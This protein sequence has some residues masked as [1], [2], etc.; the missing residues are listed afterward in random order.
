MYS[1]R[2]GLTAGALFIALSNRTLEGDSVTWALSDSLVVLPEGSAGAPRGPGGARSAWLA[3]AALALLV[4]A[5]YYPLRA[6]GYIWDDDNYVLKNIALRSAHGL[7]AIWVH[8]LHPVTPQYYP[9]TF[10]TFWVEYHLWGL[11]PLGFHVVNVAL[12]AISTLVLWRLLRALHVPAAWLAAAIFALHPVHVESVAWISER[13][14]VLS[15]L[16]YLLSLASY[17]RW[18]GI[19]R[20]AESKDIQPATPRRHLWYAAALLLFAL[21]LFSKTVTSSLPAV[22]LLMIYWKKG[23]IRWGDA[24]SLIPFFALGLTLG[25]ITS[26]LERHHVG[27]EGPE[28]DFSLLQRVGI[29]G[30]NAWFYAAKLIWPGSLNFIYPRWDLTHAAPPLL[31]AAAALA[32]P[33]ALWLAR[34]RVGRGPLV[35]VL[36]FGGS[37]FP[38]LGFV[39]LYPMRFSFV[40]DHFQYLASIGLIVLLVSGIAFLLRQAA[41]N[42]SGLIGAALGGGLILLLLISTFIRTGPFLN[43]RQLWTDT[44]Q[45]NPKAWMAYNNLAI[46]LMREGDYAGARRAIN[47]A[48]AAEPHYSYSRLNRVILD[49]LSSSGAPGAQREEQARAIQEATE[50]LQETD[51]DDSHLARVERA[52]S[53]KVLARVLFAQRNDPEAENA[54]RHLLALEPNDLEA[55]RDL[56]RVLEHRRDLN[57]ALDQWSQLIAVSPSNAQA[58]AHSALLLKQTG[59]DAPAQKELALARKI[60]PRYASYTLSSPLQY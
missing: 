16:L 19:L 26:W 15:G 58:H 23:R 5:A 43:A 34:H 2:I 55:R 39:N 8:P 42:E 35:A 12:H 6:A 1:E 3:G 21:A 4:F 30:R 41:P 59:Q 27:A 45:K 46:V 36:F 20:P 29:A 44:V 28:W 53:W 51:N 47:S 9:L 33:I 49:V 37:L 57:G 7:L 11:R 25:S 52:N 17:L 13:K 50:A 24:A 31:A 32:V 40:A 48:V 10:T 54:L 38:A 22:V 56:A 14:N 60:D 18:V